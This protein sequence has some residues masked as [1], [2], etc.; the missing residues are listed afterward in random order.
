VYESTIQ[1]HEDLV[2]DKGIRKVVSG[3]EYRKD[4]SSNECTWWQFCGKEENFSNLPSKA[5]ETERTYEDN[6]ERVYIAASRRSDRSLEARVESARRASEIHEKRTGR[7]L[8]VTEQDVLIGEMYEETDDDLPLAYRRLTAQLQ[9]GNPD[10]NNDFNK[11]LSF[12]LTHNDAMRSALHNAFQQPEK[13][14]E[15]LR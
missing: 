4:K 7:S 3:Y 14:V 5:V 2:T 6:L 9:P 10:P 1:N 13:F 8:G 11:R 15:T 12:N